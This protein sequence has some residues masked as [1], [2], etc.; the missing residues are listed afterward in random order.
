MAQV[1]TR[2]MVAGLLVAGSPAMSQ[3]AASSASS[4]D[5]TKP[6][7]FVRVLQRAGYR[8]ELKKLDSGKPYVASA[9]NGN[10]FSIYFY[11]CEQLNLLCKSFEFYSWWKKKPYFTPA[12]A[13]KWNASKRFM[14]VAVDDDGD[15]AQRLY[16]TGV[17]MTEANFL[18]LL[19]W[20]ESMDA[21]L[22]AFLKEEE[23]AAAKK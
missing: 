15:L 12:L 22:N 2:I 13:N 21:S 20:Y 1:L 10:D 17:G 11:E 6:G 8:A 4:F 3:T 9:A 19:D 18:E 16:A 7:D 14:K 5:F 23:P